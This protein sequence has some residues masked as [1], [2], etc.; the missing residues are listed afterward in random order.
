MKPG[1]GRRS[2]SRPT[3]QGVGKREFYDGEG[4]CNRRLANLFLNIAFEPAGV[5]PLKM[6]PRVYIPARL[7]QD[8][9]TDG[10]LKAFALQ[11]GAKSMKEPIRIP[12]QEVRK[13]VQAASA[14]FVCGYDVP[15]KFKANQLEGSISYQEFTSR[16]P[17]L[18]KDQE[19]IFY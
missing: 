8:H 3:G 10:S 17:S 18:S 4:G 11:G 14:L 7:L 19:I 1:I 9:H 16:L 15:E 13:K 6:S 2:L 12:P 5:A